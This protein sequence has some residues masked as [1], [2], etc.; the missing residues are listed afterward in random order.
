MA[1]QP[2]GGVEVRRNAA[3]RRQASSRRSSSSASVPFGS[4]AVLSGVRVDG[5]GGGQL[6]LS[7]NGTLV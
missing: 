3:I 1:Y 4:V 2:G 7:A 6:A 5:Q